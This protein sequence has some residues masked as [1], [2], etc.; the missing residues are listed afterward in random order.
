[1]SEKVTK[2]SGKL[3]IALLLALETTSKTSLLP[4]TSNSEYNLLL[5][6]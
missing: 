4:Q 5:K 6:S 1:M 3:S 2:A